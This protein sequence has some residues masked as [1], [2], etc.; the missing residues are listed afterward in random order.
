MRTTLRNNDEVCHFWANQVQSEGKTSNVFFEG[1]RIYSYGYHYLMGEIYASKKIALINSDGYS[2]STCRHLSSATGAL[3]CDFIRVPYPDRS[4]DKGNVEYLID[5]ALESLKKS[6]KARQNKDFYLVS[7]KKSYNEALKYCEVFNYSAK[8]LLKKVDFSENFLAELVESEKRD[9]SKRKKE[10]AAKKEAL[11]EELKE[12]LKDFR[13]NYKPI[14]RL[15]RGLLK[16]DIATIKEN[17]ILTSQGA[18][19]PLSSAKRLLIAIDNGLELAG[20]KIGPYTVSSFDGQTLKIGCH[21][22]ELSEINNLRALI[23]SI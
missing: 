13:E 7:A 9:A 15:L 17:E 10:K 8:R 4:N 19:V 5:S 1:T 22:F 6:T 16:F 3:N 21:C 2:S 23:K 12:A 20:R 18:Y 14:S 11:K